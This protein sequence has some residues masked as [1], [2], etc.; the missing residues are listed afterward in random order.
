MT[1][2]SIALALFI[3]VVALAMACGCATIAEQDQQR[4]EL[5]DHEYRL[6][7]LE[8]PDFYGGGKDESP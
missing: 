3:A 4:Q 2:L 8:A 5:I 7:R 6:R 1:R